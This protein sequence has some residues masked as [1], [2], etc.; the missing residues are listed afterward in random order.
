MEDE[1]KKKKRE[2]SKRCGL[3][4]LWISM[5]TRRSWKSWHLRLLW[6]LVSRTEGATNKQIRA[7]VAVN[8]SG[9]A[10]RQGCCRWDGPVWIGR[11]LWAHGPRAVSSRP[12]T[13]ALPCDRLITGQVAPSQLNHKLGSSEFARRTP[14]QTNSYSGCTTSTAVDK[15]LYNFVNN[16]IPKNSNIFFAIVLPYF[17]LLTPKIIPLNLI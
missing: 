8:L 6:E 5:T 17:S 16:F 2:I 10:R 4:M 3:R 12:L 13:P 9:A 15:L 14:N 1:Q 7:G 11:Y